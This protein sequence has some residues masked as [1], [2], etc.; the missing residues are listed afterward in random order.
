MVGKTPDRLARS[1]SRAVRGNGG[2]GARPPTSH[3]LSEIHALMQDAHD[4]DGIAAHAHEEDVGAGG[5]IAITGADVV[6][7]ARFAGIIGDDPDRRPDVADIALGLIVA[8]SRGC[9]VPYLV[10]IGLRARRKDDAR[11]HDL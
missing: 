2:E 1:R 6:A 8:P 11:H 9:I 3:M 5:V 4:V 7:G 10:E